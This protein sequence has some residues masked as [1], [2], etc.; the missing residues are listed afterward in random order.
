MSADRHR[1]PNPA[2][3]TNDQLVEIEID[4][5]EFERDAAYR[6]WIDLVVAE[7]GRRALIDRH[8]VKGRS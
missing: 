6:G 2:A 3:L 7:V 8:P 4:R 5:H 1:L